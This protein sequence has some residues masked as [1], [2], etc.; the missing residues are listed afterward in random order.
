MRHPAQPSIAELMERCGDGVEDRGAQ[1]AP[2]RESRELCQFWSR[3]PCERLS[4]QRVPDSTPQTWNFQRT[5]FECQRSGHS[6][7]RRGPT[8][9][10]EKLGCYGSPLRTSRSG[11][12]LFAPPTRAAVDL[13]PYTSAALDANA[14]VE[15]ITTLTNPPAERTLRIHT[16]RRTNLEKD[17]ASCRGMAGR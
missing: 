17:D 5:C 14:S 11:A 13:A 16:Q 8:R 4:F 2:R 9:R 3:L 6:P 12:P 1:E 15:W 7:E 10:G